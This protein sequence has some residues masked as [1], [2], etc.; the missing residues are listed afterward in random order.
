[1]KIVIRMPLGDEQ[2][3]RLFEIAL[4][5]WQDPERQSSVRCMAFRFMAEMVEKYPDLAVEVKLLLRP[6]LVDPLYPG[7]R[8]MVSREAKK[9]LAIK[10][11]W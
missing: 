6:N 11:T 10:S 1:M 2:E 3:G 8:R 5:Q 7:I 9:I 4:Q